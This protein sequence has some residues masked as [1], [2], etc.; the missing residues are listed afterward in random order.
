MTSPNTVLT[1]AD[2]CALTLGYQLGSNLPM[3]PLPA[4]CALSRVSHSQVNLSFEDISSS[5]V[6]CSLSFVD[7]ENQNLYASEKELLEE[8]LKK[9][10]VDA[11]HLQS[12]IREAYAQPPIIATKHP[13]T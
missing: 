1:T 4:I 3:V 11:Q 5:S 13:G 8:H 10:H 12:L 9:C 2:G 7:K 6:V